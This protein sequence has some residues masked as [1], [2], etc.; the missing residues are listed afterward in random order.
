MLDKGLTIKDAAARLDYSIATV[1]R[2][3]RAGELQSYGSGKRTRIPMSAVAAYMA[4]CTKTLDRSPLT[5]RQRSSRRHA[6]AVEE[7]AALLH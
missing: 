3:V 2:M 7:L 1:R 4:G 5:E 6:Q